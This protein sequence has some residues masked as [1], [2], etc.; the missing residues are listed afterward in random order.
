MREKG[1]VFFI[2][3]NLF[4]LNDYSSF[5]DDVLPILRVLNA[6]YIMMPIADGKFGFFCFCFMSLAGKFKS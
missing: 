6:F 1:N 2:K 5:S 3:L 4:N